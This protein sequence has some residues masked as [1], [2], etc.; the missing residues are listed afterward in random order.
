MRITIVSPFDP[1][2]PPG[3]A[4]GGAH[5]GGVERVLLR[6]AHEVAA[7]G[8]DA[9]LL[10]STEGR[11]STSWEGRLRVVRVPRRGTV[12]RAPV[13][14]LARHVP[15]ETDLVH[16][17]ATYPFTTPA[18]LR[19]ARRRG[20]PAVLDFH[21]EPDPG[22]RFGRAAAAAYRHWGPRSYPLAS[23]ALVR[24]RAYAAQ[25]PSLAR[26]PPERL[27]V[28]P[29]GVDAKQ[30]QPHGPRR[31]GSYVLVVGRLVPYKGVEV[32]IR[33]MAKLRG[34]PPLTIVGDGPLRP[35]LEGLAL[36]MGVQAAFLG[37]V[38]DE[39]LPALYRGAAL[40][41]LPSVNR[42]EAFG[43]ALVESMACG[44]PVVAS[45]LPGVAEV[46]RLGGLLARPGDADA[47]A[48]A[49]VQALQPGAVPRGEPLAERVKARYAW[50][51]LGDALL[52]YYAEALGAVPSTL[53]APEVRPRARAGRHPV[54]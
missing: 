45:D 17:P 54:L 3:E 10:C 2:P 43:I 31:A 53:Q 44:T 8:H 36:R 29:N 27:R 34:A 4:A 28:L 14:G 33:A 7:R 49:L 12:L 11:A 50:P 25:A 9:T 16:V 19:A 39:E 38:P 30:F 52:S 18:I 22:T 37:R 46:A 15:R 42:Q 35:Q 23:L 1:A 6:L 41:V 13:A 24:S 20:I 48:L 21:F 26:V 40:T 32:L 47:L 51:A 5:V